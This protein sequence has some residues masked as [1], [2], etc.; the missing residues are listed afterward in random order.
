LPRF[1]SRLIRES[2]VSIGVL[3]TA[4]VYLDRLRRHSLPKTARGMECTNHRIFLAAMVVASKYFNDV[5]AK[6]K[7]WAR[8]AGGVF[9]T[10]EVNLME[11][12]LLALLG[13]NLRIEQEE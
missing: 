12:Q 2:Q 3:M 1:I 13:Y 9:S 6:N 5:T 10:I 8:H 7:Y 4:T 11:K